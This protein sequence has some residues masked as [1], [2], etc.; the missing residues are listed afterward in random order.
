MRTG[1]IKK[2]VNETKRRLWSQKVTE[3][4]NALDL[5]KGVFTRSPRQIALSLKRSA[6]KSRRRKSSPFRSA[7]SMLT[8]YQNRA[9]SNLS[10][11]RLEAINAAKIELRKL[12]G[13]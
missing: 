6:D 8:F 12:Y 1:K 3:Q 4:S 9:G 10:K 11:S 5:E 13:R 7:M 2:T